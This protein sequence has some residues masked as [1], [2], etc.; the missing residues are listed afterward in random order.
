M[1]FENNQKLFSKKMSSK[2][3]NP[4]YKIYI[5]YKRVVV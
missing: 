2:F 1:K 4:I 5:R 3:I